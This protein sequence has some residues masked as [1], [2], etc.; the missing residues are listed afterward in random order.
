MPLYAY[1]CQDCGLTFERRQS[2]SEAPITVC[3][4]CGGTVQRLIQPVGIIFKGSGF[5]VT[6]NRG[7]SSTRLPAKTEKDKHTAE[8]P[9]ADTTTKSESSTPAA[10]SK[11]EKTDTATKTE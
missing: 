9:A 7:K 8:A 4:E 3:P 6:D 1:Q 2:F 11:V 10:T 5:Y